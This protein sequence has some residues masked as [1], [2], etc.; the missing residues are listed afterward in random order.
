MTRIETE[1]QQD[2][3]QDYFVFKGRQE[4]DALYRSY[5]ESL[6]FAFPSSLE[7]YGM[8]LLEAMAKGCPCVVFNNS[9]MPY[10]VHDGENGLVVANNDSDAFAAAVVRMVEDKELRARFSRQCVADI[11]ALPTFDNV[12]QNALRFAN[13]LNSEHF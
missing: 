7:G 8:V 9:A 13:E 5:Q 2:G 11:A 4:I 3:L 10:T 6:C 1:M 12:A